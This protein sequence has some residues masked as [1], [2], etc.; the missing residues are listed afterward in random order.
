MAV[1]LTGVIA[2]CWFGVHRIEP[3][4]PPAGNEPERGRDPVR[5][6]VY[7][8][9]APKYGLLEFGPEARHCVWLV[10]DPVADPLQPG[11]GKD[12]LY[13]DRNGNGDLTEEGERIEA[14]VHRQDDGILLGG[15]RPGTVPLLEFVV[16]DITDDAGVTHKDLRVQVGWFT[17]GKRF[18]VISAAAAGR[19]PQRSELHKLAFA[20]SPAGAPLLRFGGPLTMRFALGVVHP[21]SLSEPTELS[22]E[23]GTPGTGEGTFVSLENTS[24]PKDLHPIATIAFPHREPGGPPVEVRVVLGE[25]C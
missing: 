3:V 4:V 15:V 12:Y 10:F 14:A 5:E 7:Q 16:G 13:V 18:C 6:P 20:D 19:W 8:S 24:F 1:L 17:G 25:R 9:K 11:N 2:V 22:A 23:V 21:L